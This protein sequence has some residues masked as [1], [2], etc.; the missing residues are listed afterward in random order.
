MGRQAKSPFLSGDS[1][2]IG[3]KGGH[4]VQICVFTLDFV[5]TVTKRSQDE[6]TTRE[7]ASM[8]RDPDID[9]GQRGPP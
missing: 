3:I 9:R 7:R 1:S 2:S 8:G 4:R 6:C 5:S